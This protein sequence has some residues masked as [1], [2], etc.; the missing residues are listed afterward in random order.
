MDWLM[1]SATVLGLTIPL[2][3]GF[4]VIGIIIVGLGIIG[5][6]IYTEGDKKKGLLPRDGNPKR[7]GRGTPRRRA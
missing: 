3:I 1:N 5:G 6:E 2:I 7:L 4:A